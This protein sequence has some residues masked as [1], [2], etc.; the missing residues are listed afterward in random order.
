[1]TD[2]PALNPR[3]PKELLD[4]GKQLATKA[5]I[6]SDLSIQEIVQRIKDFFGFDIPNWEQLTANFAE[7]RQ[8]IDGTYTGTNPALLAIQGTIG[9][10][11]R[12]AAGIIEPW[13]LPLIPL[14]HIGEASPNLLENGGFDGTMPIEETEGWTFN[15]TIG[16]TSAGSAQ[17]TGNGTRRVLLSNVVLCAPEQK[18]DIGGFVTW[19]MLTGGGTG[20][21]KLSAVAYDDTESVVEEKVI[22]QIDSPSG[23]QAWT[24]LLGQYVVPAGATKIRVQVEV[25][26]TVTGGTVN[27]DDLS[28]TKYGNLPQRMVAG[29]VSALGDL[30][31]GIAA[32]VEGVG[33]FFDKL[34]GKIGTTIADIQSWVAQLKTILSGGIVGSGIFPSL[35]EGAVVDVI[36][37][38]TGFLNGLGSSSPS[39]SL[40]E[41]RAALDFFTGSSSTTAATADEAQGIG[42][43]ALNNTVNIE[44]RLGGVVDEIQSAVTARALWESMDYTAD[45]T[46]PLYLMMRNTAHIHGAS[47]TFSLNT[48]SQGGFESIDISGTTSTESAGG[49][50]HSHSFSDSDSFSWSHVHSVNGTI[51]TTIASANSEYSAYTFTADQAYVGFFRCRSVQEKRVFTFRGYYTAAITDLRLDIYLLSKSGTMTKLHQSA[52][53]AGAITGVAQWVQYVIPSNTPGINVQAGDI[54]AVQFSIASGTMALQGLD[55]LIPSNLA[56]YLP[57][58]IG[59]LRSGVVANRAPA[60]MAESLWGAGA[61]FIP[62]VEAGVDTGQANAPISITDNFNGSLSSQWLMTGPNEL[63]IASNNLGIEP[64]GTNGSTGISWARFN[65]QLRTDQSKVGFTTTAPNSQRQIVWFHGNGPNNHVGLAITASTA[66]LY[67]ASGGT[68]TQ[69]AQ[70]SVSSA[71]ASYEIR[72][73][74]TTKVYSVWRN[75]SALAGCSW[76]DSG[77]VTPTGLGNRFGGVAL[78]GTRGGFFGLEFDKANPIDDWLLADVA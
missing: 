56:G 4:A 35:A 67:T 28:V 64:S 58:R 14:S 23:A 62:Y 74:A 60:T 75:G 10:L 45:A 21:F 57:R 46:I 20:A 37:G 51:T 39:N 73:D 11:R 8:A 33:N 71:A 27:W 54:L 68:W 7:L 18:F 12:L 41:M 65:T 22:A 44:T 40:D 34:T 47:S 50:S 13:R 5:D 76:T 25:A 63:Y 26:A 24:A 38:V 9:V 69:R 66:T 55:S 78:E 30:G 19:S 6:T 29:L 17:T 3:T 31:A 53:I 72:Y 43:N 15:P 70:V 42:T 36:K 48:N 1:M 61:G 77:N 16:R 49:S 2:V 52:N 59:M 32:A